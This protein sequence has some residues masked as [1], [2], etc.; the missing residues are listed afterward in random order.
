[1]AGPLKPAQATMPG[2][3]VSL[4]G[5]TVDLT[6]SDAVFL[7]LRTNRSIRSAYLERIAEKFDLRV[8]EDRFNPK[9]LLTGRY[10][11]NRNQDERFNTAE[12]VPAAT[13]L[14][15]L[16]TRFSLS[17]S[18]QSTD[19]KRGGE[20][21][22]DKV[23]TFSVIQPLL[24]GGGKSAATASLRMARLGEQANK[25]KLK[26]AVSD[27]VM[28]IIFAYHEVLRAQEQLKIARDGLERS[29]Q[30]L[31]VN[32]AMI[33]AGRMAEFDAVQTEADSASQELMVEETTNQLAAKRLDLL[34]LLALD[35]NTRITVIDSPVARRT[36]I[37]LS[38]ALSAAFEQRPAYLSQII[39]SEQASIRLDLA[40][41]EQLWDVSLVGEASQSRLSSK[42]TQVGNNSNRTWD[43]Y[44]GVQVEIPIGDLS[45]KQSEVR[46]KVDAENQGVLLAEAKQALELEV[47]NAVRD[48]GTR[49]RQYEIAQ[50]ALTLSQRKLE[51]EREKLRVGRSSNFQVLSYESD[52]RN[53]ENA[54]LDALIAYLN[55]QSTLDNTLG[56]TLESW[57]ISLND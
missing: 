24:R 3:S 7:G 48:L 51:V 44:A 8:E 43:G 52:L 26:M 49:W 29:R 4:S 37:S 38:T 35:S 33:A 23:A 50:R 22:Q 32:K 31:E 27:T 19:V 6:L 1:M 30:L 28:Q 5:Q 18:Y 2:K 21:T 42:R 36:E 56:T 40:R 10:L 11:V 54:S 17:W 39:A 45:I 34:R 9:L 14:S 15:K 13:L 25:L 16:G 12:V 57:D 55:A 20:L 41:N 53:A 46:A 47:D